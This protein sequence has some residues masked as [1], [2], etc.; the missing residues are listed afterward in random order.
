MSNYKE[1]LKHITTFIFDYDGVLTDG[2]VILL[3]DDEGLRTAH[4]KDGY[5]M[6][7]AI[8]KGYR[9]AIISGGRSEAINRRF[10]VLDVHDVFMGVSDK[11]K[12][13][14][15]Y[16][17]KNKLKK[18]EILFMGDDIPDYPLMKQAG[19][20]T[21]PANASEEIKSV[22]AYISSLNGGDGCVRDVIE[23]VLK[24]Q[25]KWFDKQTAFL[26]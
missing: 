9:V 23:Q 14:T 24:V 2:K 19:I 21:C 3:N 16:L 13:Y 10:K 22:A 5:A 15:D 6:Q 4:V 7:Y 18:E 20:A 1:K 25:G 26:W 12:V 17:K 11:V 8:K